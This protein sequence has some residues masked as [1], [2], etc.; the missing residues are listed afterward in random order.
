MSTTPGLT[1]QHDA[2]LDGDEHHELL[3]GEA[4]LLPA[5]NENTRVSTML[6]SALGCFN[7]VNTTS[8]C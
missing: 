2:N 8:Y 3:D 1:C 5:P 6:R 4:V 7:L